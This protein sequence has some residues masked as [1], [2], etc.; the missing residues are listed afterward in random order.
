MCWEGADDFE[1]GI[2]DVDMTSG[3]T[4]EDVIGAR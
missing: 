1:G 3:S 4:K 2:A